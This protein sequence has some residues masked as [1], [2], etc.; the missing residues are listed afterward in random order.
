VLVQCSF[1]VVCV[2]EMWKD[3]R[4]KHSSQSATTVS[5][6]LYR[7]VFEE[8]NITF[9]QPS[10]DD[11][12]ICTAFNRHH[13]DLTEHP[14]DCA[15]CAASREHLERAKN[16]RHEYHKTNS[17]KTYA[18]D[19]QKIILLP[20]LT[21]KQH[22]FVSR[23]VVFNETFA[24]LNEGEN[25]IA[26]L[27][28]EAINGRNAADVAAA[29][30]KCLELSN[31]PTV[32]I[33]ADNCCG[34]NKNW[35]LFT[36]MCLCVNQE[37]GPNEV[38]IKYLEKGH[39]YMKADSIHGSI[40]KKLK[41]QAEILTFPDFVDLVDSSSKFLKPVV[42]GTA[43]FY[44]FS[45]EN[46]TRKTK[47]VTL[48]LLTNI[49]SVTFKK[50]SRLMFFKTDFSQEDTAVDFLKPKFN[51]SSSFPS[52]HTKHRGISSSKRDGILQLLKEVPSTKK[53]FWL[54]LTTCE[55]SRDLVTNL[56]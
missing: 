49:C 48:P 27:W 30:V 17:G 41:K 53:K 34:Q 25:D 12:E 7:R 38:T 40:G 51:V 16:A 6:E 14:P 15:I 33:W 19:M 8:E 4:T 29:Y 37:W 55:T 56:E 1:N 35:T 28:H 9:G 36:T 18:A 20:K 43:D 2:T 42:L 13:S 11:C 23:L 39:T 3:F 47:N 31:S 10:Q 21:T 45:A 46:R 50:D 26:V 22:F 54:E 32:T 44:E 5:Y 24:C 52:P